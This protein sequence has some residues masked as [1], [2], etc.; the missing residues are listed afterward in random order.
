MTARPEALERLA[1][2]S[3][4][5]HQN[6]RRGIDPARPRALDPATDHVR[7]EGVEVIEYGH[8][9][10]LD[11]VAAHEELASAAQLLDQRV[12]FGFRHFPLATPDVDL[13]LGAAEASEAAAAQGGFW[14]MHDRLLAPA[15]LFGPHA[16]RVH[17][18]ELGLDLDRFDREVADGTHLD[19]ILADVESGI[20]AGVDGTP[21]FFVAGQRIDG[22][23]QREELT[24]SLASAL[25][26]SGVGAE[27]ER[28]QQ[29]AALR[30]AA[31]TRGRRRG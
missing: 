6:A 17:A 7:G 4:T 11:A 27:I 30:D 23:Y 29:R 9:L 16:F 25:H 19:R 26:D 24:A 22:G 8:Y 14:E 1:E 10:E 3:R 20:A 21:T 5:W 18:Q 28:E 15:S 13:A 31:H 12:R 2:M